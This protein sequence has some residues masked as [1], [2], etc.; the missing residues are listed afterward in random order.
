M[1][2]RVFRELE[3]HGRESIRGTWLG[4][5]LLRTVSF[6]TWRS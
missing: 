4:S 5:S 6:I 1:S 3:L 2:S